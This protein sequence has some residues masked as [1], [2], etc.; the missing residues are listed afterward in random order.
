MP[1]CMKSKNNMNKC[2][3]L[4]HSLKHSLRKKKEAQRSFDILKAWEAT[5]TNLPKDY[6][7]WTKEE[8]IHMQASLDSWHINCLFSQDL[9][10]ETG[11][12]CSDMWDQALDIIEDYEMPHVQFLGQSVP[13]YNF[14]TDMNQQISS[15]VDKVTRLS[16]WNVDV[17][18]EIIIRPTECSKA[19]DNFLSKSKSGNEEIAKRIYRCKLNE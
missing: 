12:S 8:K 1:N 19:M 11:K 6:S 14:L 2:Y 9:I 16:F 15:Q 18:K 7:R 5:R 3:S 10:K 13:L 17:V 4:L